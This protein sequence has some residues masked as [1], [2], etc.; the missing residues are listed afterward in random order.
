MIESWVVNSY[1]G[2]SN[3]QVSEHFSL[4]EHKCKGCKFREDGD[5]PCPGAH[6][7]SV[8]L[9]WRLERLRSL[10]NGAP[11]YITSGYRCEFWNQRQ[12][13]GVNSQH[14]L[15]RAVDIQT[16]EM[17]DKRRDPKAVSAIVDRLAAQAD[18]VGFVGIGKYP[19]WIHVDVREG[20]KA[21]WTN[22]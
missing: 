6:L 16:A 18:L 19:R 20:R 3:C 12:G 5:L 10:N 8:E 17:R 13:G 2:R 21:R 9:Y 14:L 4:N 22:R 15:G 1:P 7:V 11:I